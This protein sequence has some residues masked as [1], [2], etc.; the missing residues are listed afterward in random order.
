MNVTQL[1]FNTAH[2]FDGSVDA[3]NGKMAE[4][5]VDKIFELPIKLIN[6]PPRTLDRVVLA[7]HRVHEGIRSKRD[8]VVLGVLANPDVVV[9]R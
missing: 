3:I 1:P 6:L 4:M 9:V 5:S 7:G 8:G 2:V